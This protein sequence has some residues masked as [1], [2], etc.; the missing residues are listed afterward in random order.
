MSDA[1]VYEL[2]TIEDVF[3][4]VP[5]D[6]IMEC[7]VEMGYSLSQAK[8]LDEAAKQ[9]GEDL[10]LKW[11]HSVQWVDDGKRQCGYSVSSPHGG[12]VEVVNGE[13]KEFRHPGE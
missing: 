6:R 2:R 7:M 12:Y 4:K 5:A 8:R 10:G 3:T 1:N 9:D 11:P 13:L